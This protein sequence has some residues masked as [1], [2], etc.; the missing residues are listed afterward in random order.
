MTAVPNPSRDLLETVVAAAKVSPGHKQLIAALRRSTGLDTVRVG[1]ERDGFSRM[2]Q[3]NQVLAPDAMSLGIYHDWI[4]NELAAANGDWRAVWVKFRGSDLRLTGTEIVKI[5]LVAPYGDA[6]SEFLQ[7]VINLNQSKI[8]RSLFSEADWEVPSDE[9]DLREL[10]RCS[11]YPFSDPEPYG[12]PCYELESV[13]NLAD[14]LALESEL[15]EA[16]KRAVEH[17]VLRIDNPQ[18]GEVRYAGIFDEF[19]ELRRKKPRLARFFA[20]WDRS[21]AGRSGAEISR[22]WVFE[23][24]DYTNPKTGE[25]NLSVIPAWTA[26]KRLAEIKPKPSRTVFHLWDELLRFDVRAGYQFAWY[27]F[28]LH[29]NRIGSWVGERILEAA[30]AG[31]IV[32][33]EQDYR[34]LKDWAVMPYGF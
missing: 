17:K 31:S 8:E 32:M 25:R 19:P 11:G 16:Q 6:S 5:R 33:P 15:E 13:S 18:T 21:S 29:G 1:N 24:S 4:A 23:I 12:E 26:T 34:V 3:Y 28:M 14:V 2:A 10:D 7:L 27:F 22:H 30:E 20:D 9:Q